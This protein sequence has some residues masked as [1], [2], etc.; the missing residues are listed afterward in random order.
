MSGTTVAYRPLSRLGEAW[1]LVRE[2]AWDLAALGL[3]SVRR[4]PDRVRVDY[5][6]GVWK[7]A[8]EKRAWS[9]YPTLEQ[10]VISDDHSM[11]TAKI[12]N[13]LV[14]IRT[15]DYYRYRHQA[16]VGVLEEFARGEDELIEL[17]CGSGLNLFVLA[18]WGRWP[19]LR[20]LDVSENAIAVGRAVARHFSVTQVSFDRLDMIEETDPR[21]ALLR[22]KTVFTYYCL[23]QLRHAFDRVIANLLRSGVR[24][25]INI[26][27]ST[28][29]LPR[30]S[31]QRLANT[32][33]IRRRDYLPALVL[34]LRQA[35]RVGKLRVVAA[36]RLQYAP[37]PKNDP[38]LVVWEPTGSAPHWSA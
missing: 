31:L 22:G 6:L 8:L 37:S 35:E 26:E 36:R 34:P 29:L 23:E 17:G 10:Y 24:R 15:D 28:E 4:T 38:V 20:G 14:R 19:T 30:Y 16:L 7:A 12:D 3:R 27:T 21:F 1:C 5:D 9:R 11:R 18:V 33:Y 2:I 32:L 13:Q 25:V